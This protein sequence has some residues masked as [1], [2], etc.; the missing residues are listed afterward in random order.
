MTWLVAI[1]RE[2]GIQTEAR[3]ALMFIPERID[4]DALLRVTFIGPSVAMLPDPPSGNPIVRC[5]AAA[6]AALLESRHDAASSLERSGGAGWGLLLVHSHRQRAFEFGLH[7]R[8]LE[9]IAKTQPSSGLLHQLSL[10]IVNNDAAELLPHGTWH[11]S[12]EDPIHWLRL[13]GGLHMRLRMLTVTSANFGYLCGEFQALAAAAPLL[14]QF[15]WVLYTSGPDVLPTPVGVLRLSTLI[16]QGWSDR[17]NAATGGGSASS[18]TRPALLYTHFPAPPSKHRISMDLFVFKPKGVGS[19]W[20]GAAKMCLLSG[21]TASTEQVV[22]DVAAENN[23][24]RLDTWMQGYQIMRGAKL[25]STRPRENAAL[26]HSHN[27]SAV[28][29]W[30]SQQEQVHNITPSRPPRRG[31]LRCRGFKLAVPASMSR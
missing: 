7:A 14:S 17:S 10:L 2:V 22:A 1:R 20:T 8:M 15:P 19:L 30:L 27:T 18:S 3:R 5:G 21:G 11:G 24:S 9:L 13:Y 6:D 28:A 29:A 23:V 26:W 16:T 4:I 31:P 25:I 12:T